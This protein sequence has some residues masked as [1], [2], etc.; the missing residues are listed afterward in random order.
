MQMPARTK[1]QARTGVAQQ[2]THAATLQRQQLP[3]RS[4][5]VIGHWMIWLLRYTQ[6]PLCALP[7]RAPYQTGAC[8]GC[9]PTACAHACA[10]PSYFRAFLCMAWHAC[11]ARQLIVQPH[12]STSPFNQSHSLLLSC[13]QTA[14]PLLL[15]HH[16]FAKHAHMGC[17]RQG[18]APSA[19]ACRA[20]AI[21][22]A[23]TSLCLQ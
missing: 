23:I 20:C 19:Y 21:I 8:A 22:G 3:D 5:G 6:R 11:I 4:A 10:W 15:Q 17:Q 9:W 14:G 12:S 7:L 13:T 16:S 2:A 18:F 1:R